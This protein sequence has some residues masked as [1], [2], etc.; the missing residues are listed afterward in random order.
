MTFHGV[1]GSDFSFTNFF[2]IVI[3]NVENAAVAQ[4]QK[5]VYFFMD[6]VFFIR[7]VI[8]FLWEIS[9]ST[10]LFYVD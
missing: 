3:K 8:E 10:F 2:F 5:F 6:L 1:Y 9:S 4:N 7:D